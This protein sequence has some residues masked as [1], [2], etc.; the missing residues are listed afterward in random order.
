MNRSDLSRRWRVHGVGKGIP[1][2]KVARRALGVVVVVLGVTFGAF[3]LSYLSPT[4]A[5]TQYFSSKGV[6]PTPAELA[7]KRA[8]F[9]LDRPFLVQYVS[10]LGSM[11]QGDLGESY[12]SGRPVFDT[13]MG[14]LP[15]TI[16]LTACSMLLVLVIA[17]PVGLICAYRK[18][19]LFDNIVRALT[20]MFN[21]LPTFFVALMLLYVL[22][23]RLH[24]FKVNATL[25]LKGLVM[26]SLAMALPLSAWYIRQ[27]RAYF[28]EQLGSVYVDGLRSRGASERAILFKHVLRN[29]L[30]P[31]LS[32]VGISVGSMLGGTAIVESIFNWPG[33]GNL[34]VAAISTR[35]Y[36]VVEGYALL[37]AIVYLIV[38]AL[39]DV[40]Y[41]L[42]DP[43]VAKEAR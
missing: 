38:N 8:E 16:A 33:V 27:V 35:D 23:V 34:S 1:W 30:V 31:I 12:R 41:R 20:Y 15:Y 3:L 36:P 10:W 25:D 39:V 13:L 14:G 29:S 28:L 40:A 19:G 6:A 17:L 4:D 5:A 42:A 11:L 32:L 24:L 26:P 43:R 7:A 22:A 2:A 18:D 37:M 9:G 21:A